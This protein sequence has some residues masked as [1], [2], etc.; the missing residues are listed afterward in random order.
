[1]TAILLSNCTV[2]DIT[3]SAPYVPSTLVAVTFR[4]VGATVSYVVVSETVDDSE[5]ASLILAD[6]VLSSLVT[7]QPVAPEVISKAGPSS[8]LTTSSSG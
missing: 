4:T 8:S 5:E 1:M 2:A 6:I 3:V 7:E